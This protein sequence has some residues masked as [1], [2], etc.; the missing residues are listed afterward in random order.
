[1]EAEEEPIFKEIYPVPTPERT[2]GENHGGECEGVCCGDG[3]AKR[4]SKKRAW[5]KLILNEEEED[6]VKWIVGGPG[7]WLVSGKG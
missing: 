5:R 1:M 4:K 6:G 2:R 3:F 7:F